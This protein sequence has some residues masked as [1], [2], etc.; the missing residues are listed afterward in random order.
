MHPDRDAWGRCAH[1]GHWQGLDIQD[2]DVLLVFHG[3]IGPQHER[4]DALDLCCM[5]ASKSS[6]PGKGLE[7]LCT[8]SS[9]FLLGPSGGYGLVSFQI[10]MWTETCSSSQK[11]KLLFCSLPAPKHKL[12]KSVSCVV[13]RKSLSQAE[14]LN[15]RP[16]KN[17][18]V[19]EGDSR[20]PQSSK[21]PSQRLLRRAMGGTRRP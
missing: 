1:Y 2:D 6:E 18:Q 10:P 19:R 17:M 11:H 8:V 14:H 3:C 15:T 5:L 20:V 16:L 21:A 9:D 13:S 7:I 4:Q 12:F